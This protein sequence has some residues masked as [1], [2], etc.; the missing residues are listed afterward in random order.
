MLVQTKPIKIEKP[1]LQPWPFWKVLGGALLVRLLI[2]PLNHPWDTQTWYNLLVDLNQHHS[3]Y[4]TFEQLSLFARSAKINP[5]YEYFAYPPGLIYLY[6]P[7]AR[8]YALFDPY[9][10]YHFSSPGTFPSFPVPFLATLFFKLPV[11]AADLATGWLLQKMAGRRIALVYLFN[12]YVIFM[13]GWMFDSLMV[14]GIVAALYWLEEGKLEQSA[15][16]LAAGTLLK[17][18]PLFIIPALCVYL[19]TNSGYSYKRIFRSGLI[20]LF[21]VGLPCLPF[22]EGLSFVLGFH[23]QRVGGG[24]NGQSIWYFLA[25]WFPTQRWDDYIFSFSGALGL[26]VLIGGI[27]L[28]CALVYRYRPSA[29]ATFCAALAGYLAFTKIVNEVYALP[30]VPLL[31]LLVART[32]SKGLE[33]CYKL[34]WSI[35]L[36]FAMINVPFFHFELNF[37]TQLDLTNDQKAIQIST[38]QPRPELSLFLLIAGLFFSGLCLTILFKSLK[39][40]LI[41]REDMYNENEDNPNEAYSIS[42]LHFSASSASSAVKNS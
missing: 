34:L 10:T 24:L 16:A 21:A 1:G 23:G 7:V 29:L 2:T 28:T 32:G 27:L 18:V 5:Y 30:L 39:S 19:F 12:P 33:R 42:A 3:P 41:K 11:I 31:L 14:L 40:N 20:Y 36:T 25:S 9:L 13:S 38:F 37:L 6:Y 8:L 35:P 4:A 22:A 15:V 26:L 17:F